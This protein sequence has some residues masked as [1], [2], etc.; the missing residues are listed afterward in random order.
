M[1]SPNYNSAKVKVP[2]KDLDVYIGQKV[3]FRRSMLGVSQDKLGSCL[4][5]TF[6]QIQKYEKGTNRVSASMLYNIASIL[7]VDIAYFVE[8]FDE[9]KTLHDD[10]TPAYDVD[11]SKRKESKETA[12]LLKSYYKIVDPTMRKKIFDIVKTFAAAN[13]KKA[14]IV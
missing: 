8:G 10:N 6:Q 2:H 11:F 4:G 12:D 13:S 1:I 7:N 3:K 14:D 5:I 9:R